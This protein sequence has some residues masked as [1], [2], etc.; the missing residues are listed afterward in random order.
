[1][2]EVLLIVRKWWLCVGQFN[3]DLLFITIRQT[4]KHVLEGA[5]VM[6]NI[7]HV[8]EV[9]VDHLFP[10]LALA[11]TAQS[12]LALMADLLVDVPIHSL[13]TVGLSGPIRN[14]K[15]LTSEPSWVRR[16]NWYFLS[17]CSTEEMLSLMWTWR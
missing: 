16:S 5:N 7:I 3:M 14:W 13:L 8:A 4:G 1:M 12:T 9:Q 10:E 15:M 11:L 2:N 17:C 6:V